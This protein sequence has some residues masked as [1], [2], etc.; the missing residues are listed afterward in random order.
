ML[1]EFEQVVRPLTDDISVIGDAFVDLLALHNKATVGHRARPGCVSYDVSVTATVAKPS[2]LSTERLRTTPAI[3]RTWS[4]ALSALL[5]LA[6]VTASLATLAFDASVERVAE[7]TGPVLIS[8]QGLVASIAE[9]DAANTAVFLSGD[10]QDRQQ[11]SLFLGAMSRAPQQIEDISAG[12]DD[13]TVS[14][15]ALKQVGSQLVEYSQLTERARLNNLANNSSATADLEESLELVAGP[16]GM[17]ANTQIINDRTQAS[18]TNETN[19][20]SVLWIVSIISLI[21][22]FIG[23]LVAQYNLRR[24]TK[25]L[26]NVP[27]VLA[28]VCVLVLGVWLMAALVGRLSDLQLAQN[29]AYN[30]IALTADLQTEAFEFKTQE[31]RAIINNDLSLFDGTTENRANVTALLSSMSAEADS[32]RERAAIANLQQ[33]WNRYLGT[34]EQIT[35]ALSV[36]GT[37]AARVLAISDGNRDFNGFNTTVETVLLSNRDQFNS[38][39]E[40]AANRLKFLQ[41][42]SI[43]LPLLALAFMLLGYQARINEYW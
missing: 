33:R 29:D 7:N 6:A 20:G 21:L 19:S 26:I 25:R 24:R 42:G 37:E 12:L 27:L 5:I 34:N 30:T 36:N 28:T 17:L 8:T 40:S 9:A 23:L 11:R 10:D 38:A 15:D 31:A 22:A 3:L 2:W 43:L 35:N 14:H 18:F 4:V 39:I 1:V 32:Q 16:D 41:L 13:D